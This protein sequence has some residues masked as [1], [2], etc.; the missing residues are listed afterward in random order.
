M[1]RVV[2]QRSCSC[3]KAGVTDI[4]FILACDQ[5]DLSASLWWKKVMLNTFTP[6]LHRKC[7]KVNG[8]KKDQLKQREP[9]IFYFI[10]DL[11]YSNNSFILKSLVVSAYLIT[12][13]P[14]A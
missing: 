4:N 14:F 12:L 7:K 10:V 6:R 2:V 5:S 3:L 8:Y 1:F 11:I 9:T 13:N